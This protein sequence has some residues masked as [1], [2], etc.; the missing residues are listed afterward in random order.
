MEKENGTII[1]EEKEKKNSDLTAASLYFLENYDGNYISAMKKIFGNTGEELTENEKRSLFDNHPQMLEYGLKVLSRAREEEAY[2]LFIK[3]IDNASRYC[4]R[5]AESCLGEYHEYQIVGIETVK[6]SIVKEH[7]EYV[8]ARA[9][10]EVPFI[11]DD[12]G[13]NIRRDF[14]RA[15][16]RLC[17]LVDGNCPKSPIID[18]DSY[19]RY[20]AYKGIKSSVDYENNIFAFGEKPE[21]EQ[22]EQPIEKK[23]I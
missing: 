19:R 14:M 2:E 13:K 3:Y 10:V 21:K 8:Y 18:L 12:H 7:G 22:T 23:L 17:C 4:A 16:R 5:L 6:D 11:K 15:S 20:I 9:S 1:I